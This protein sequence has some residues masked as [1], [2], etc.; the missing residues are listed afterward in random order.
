VI[1]QKFK[2]NCKIYASLITTWYWSNFFVTGWK[3]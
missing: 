2:I 1:I 3:N